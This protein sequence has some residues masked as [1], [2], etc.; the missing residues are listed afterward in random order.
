[1]PVAMDL[2]LF[3]VQPG[4]QNRVSSRGGLDR[5]G[6]GCSG[7]MV[8]GTGRWSAG[9]GSRPVG[10]GSRLAAGLEERGGGRREEAL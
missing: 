1:M 7:E 10:L 4:S 3:S 5:V 6:G 9:Q 2:L 8:G